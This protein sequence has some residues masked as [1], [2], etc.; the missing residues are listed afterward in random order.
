MC[1]CIPVCAIV[2]DVAYFATSLM[3]VDLFRFILFF[4]PADVVGQVESMC[5]LG[6]L[7]LT[8]A[9]GLDKDEKEG[10]AP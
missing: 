6:G 9:E 1:V 7:L 2:F 4:F 8:G 3:P 10:Y 5:N